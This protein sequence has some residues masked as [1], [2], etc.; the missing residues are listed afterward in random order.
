MSLKTTIEVI[1]IVVGIIGATV[2]TYNFLSKKIKEIT[3][4]KINGVRFSAQ[5]QKASSSL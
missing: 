4:N 1:A 5:N 2:T 3:E